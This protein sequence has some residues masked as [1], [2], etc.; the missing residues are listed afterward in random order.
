MLRVSPHASA[1]TDRG[2]NVHDRSGRGGWLPA[3][4]QQRAEVVLSGHGRQAL[5]HVGEVG[6]RVV[7]VAL[8]T[9]HHGVDDRGALAGGFAAHEEP[10][11]LSNCHR[12]DPVLYADMLFMRTSF[13]Q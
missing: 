8:G 10:G 7:A 6:F 4:R 12:P 3:R 11:F 13:A 2:F 5:E 9:F 1:Q